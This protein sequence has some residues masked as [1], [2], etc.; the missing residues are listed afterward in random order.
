MIDYIHKLTRM[1]Y[2]IRDKINLFST[3]KASSHIRLNVIK[4]VAFM[5]ELGV[6]KPIY[7]IQFHSFSDTRQIPKHKIDLI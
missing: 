4:L 3:L 2:P 1:T 6:Y 5:S 7:I